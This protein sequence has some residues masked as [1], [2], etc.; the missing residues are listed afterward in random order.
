[1][2]N[3]LVWPLTKVE[4]KAFL[5]DNLCFLFK[6]SFF[7]LRRDV[8]LKRVMSLPK[9]WFH[10]PFSI[11]IVC[12]EYSLFLH[13]ILNS[14]VC[15]SSLDELFSMM[16]SNFL[17]FF[18]LPRCKY[19]PNIYLFSISSV[20]FNEIILIRLF[21]NDLTQQ[22]SVGEVGFPHHNPMWIFCAFV[23]TWL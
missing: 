17:N 19:F 1:M 7:V 9:T 20:C 12:P 5:K 14:L 13:L 23:M 11:P 21:L 10:H 8:I 6:I 15:I 16:C 3:S 22:A 2:V 4:N 18:L